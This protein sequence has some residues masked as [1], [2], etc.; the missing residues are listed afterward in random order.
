MSVFCCIPLSHNQFSALVH[1]SFPSDPPQYFQT[2]PCRGALLAVGLQRA[3]GAMRGGLCSFLKLPLPSSAT[4]RAA[5]PQGSL[6]QRDAG[7]QQDGCLASCCRESRADGSASCR[8]KQ[9]KTQKCLQQG[10]SR[11]GCSEHQ[12]LFDQLES[13]LLSCSEHAFAESIAAA[14]AGVTFASSSLSL[15]D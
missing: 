3:S 5:L 14:I 10:S 9:S 7:L 8:K 1:N 13:L 2:Y 12:A 11:E 15:Q 4:S 6:A